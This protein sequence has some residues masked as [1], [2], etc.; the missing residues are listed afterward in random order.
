M[1]AKE[2]D[3][4]RQALDK[5]QLINGVNAN[6]EPA[7]RQKDA[8]I[9]GRL[10][11][12]FQNVKIHFNAEIKHEVR[13]Y[14]LEKLIALAGKNEPFMLIANRIFPDIKRQLREHGIAYLDGAGNLYVNHKG[15]LAWIEGNKPPAGQKKPPN[16]AF[17]KAGLKVLFFFLNDPERLNM[18]YRDIA[19]GAGVALGNINLVF[20]GLRDGGFLLQLDKKNVALQNEEELLER[21]IAGY[22]E[23]LKPALHLGNFRMI[24]NIADWKELRLPDGVIWGGEPA[25]NLLT[26]NLN[27]EI[28][29]VYTQLPKNELMKTLRLMPDAGGNIKIYQRFWADTEPEVQ[30]TPPLLTYADLL[31]TGDSRCIEVAA[32]IKNEHLQYLTHQ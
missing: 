24:N 25:A 8:E 31:I 14:Q 20:A 17:T 9:D 7:I 21:W 11:L 16:R 28:L 13:H 4:L 32:T 22:R 5:L 18:T 23:T 15:Q 2:E 12:D 6:W 10:L 30:M 27:P 3:V 19:D 29:T 1:D 26:R